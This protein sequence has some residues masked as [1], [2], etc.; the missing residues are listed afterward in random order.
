MRAGNALFF[1][2]AFAVF[3]T[4]PALAHTA[5]ETEPDTSQNEEAVAA[6]A[7]VQ[8]VIVGGDGTEVRVGMSELLMGT[9]ADLITSH[10][11]TEHKVSMRVDRKDGDQIDLRVAYRRGDT[12]VIG[13]RHVQGAMQTPTEIAGPGV[14]LS[15]L[16]IPKTPRAPIELPPGSDD[17][18]A[19]V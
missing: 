15:V 1:A 2:A 14:V 4:S 9:D 12:E 6:S 11:G 13:V 19:G 10:E 3:G 7:E 16:V 8:V 18:L 17:P 5:E